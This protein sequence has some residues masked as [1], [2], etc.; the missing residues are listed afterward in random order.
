MIEL[1]KP[2]LW[3]CK[4]KAEA[5]SSDIHGQFASGF[6]HK[7]DAQFAETCG[8]VVNRCKYREDIVATVLFLE[9]GLQSV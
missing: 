2:Q 7:E 9:G 5:C 3:W 8:E 6:K 4:C 1:H